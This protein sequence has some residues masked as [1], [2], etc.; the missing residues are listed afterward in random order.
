MKN[1]ENIKKIAEKE[2][3]ELND[4]IKILKKWTTNY[5]E[6]NMRFLKMF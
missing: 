1:L 6:K 3:L 5:T 4:L 2:G